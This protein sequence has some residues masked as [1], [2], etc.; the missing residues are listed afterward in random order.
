M[1]EFKLT[2]KEKKFLSRCGCSQYRIYTI[3]HAANSDIIEYRLYDR[4]I[5]GPGYR[6]LNRDQAMQKV[7]RES[8]ICALNR[9]CEDTYS[10]L[11]TNLEEGFILYMIRR[12]K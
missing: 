2:S 7:C 12:Q 5:G 10:A 11:I 3:E 4:N 9:F 1:K 6:I 8:Y